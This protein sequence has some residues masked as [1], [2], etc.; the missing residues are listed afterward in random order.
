[1]KM[2]F[3]AAGDAIIQR[4][5]QDDFEGLHEI[6]PFVQRGDARFF[7]LETTLHRE[8]ECYASQFSG[9]TY[10][11]TNPE[12]L[13]DIKKF[14]FNMT[15]FNNNHAMDFSYEGLLHTLQH[16]EDS[17]LVHSGVGRNLDEASAPRYLETPNG[18]VALIAVN[19]SFEPCMMAGKQGR[20]VPGRPGVN[21]LRVEKKL[22]VTKEELDFI[23]NLAGKMNINAENEIERRGGYMAPLPEEEA[24]FAPLRFVL[25]EETKYTQKMNADD[26]KR[27]EQAIY[28]AEFQADYTIVS[29]H[30]HDV[31]GDTEEI[32]PDV[33]RDF[34]HAC[35]DAGANAVVGHGPHLLRPIE[36]YKDSPI[37][38]SLGDFMI[39]L[40]SVEFAPEDF[41]SRYGL[42]TD[43]TMHELLKTRSK[44]FSIGLMTER[45]MFQTVIPYWETKD[46]KII[47]LELLPVE[48]KMAGHKSE[49]G[50]PRRA[51][52]LAFI[53]HLTEMSADYGVR[54]NVGKDG[55]VTCEW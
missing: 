14:G 35:I 3:T 34:A 28:E 53:E 23:K 31:T 39:Q 50:L 32:V 2:K 29:I 12:M 52:D 9:G 22:H 1:M 55:I 45:K 54:M 19:T 47:K 27:V 13:E 10:I 37:F 4:R 11:R 33:L 5:M 44:D 6:A 16:L 24:E 41:Y 48:C 42:T 8:G 18:R 25:D 38:Y 49:I 30:S 40:Y 46:K 7:N 17:G 51:T 20:R 43:S 36:I 21:G 15:S 26:M